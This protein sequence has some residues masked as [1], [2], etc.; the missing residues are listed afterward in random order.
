M[1]KILFFCLFIFMISDAF[2]SHI[3]G[4][5]MSY[6]Y[7]GPGTNPGT[8]KYQVTLKMYKDCA[9]ATALDATVLFSVYNTA[10]AT[11]FINLTG[12]A[13]SAIQTIQKSPVDP[14]IDDNIETLVCF[15]YRTYTTIIDNLPITPDGYTIAF[16]RCCR[17]AGMENIFSTDVGSTF[18]TVIPG[19][20]IAGAETNTS[21]VFKGFLILISV[22]MRRME[23]HWFILFIM[24]FPEEV[25]AL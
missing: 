24:H 6:I 14:C 4:G 17:V 12:I 3:S 22:Q 23:I 19:D 7:L 8:L 21:P 2:A 25:Q 5:E 1:K 20:L 18:F 16:Q 15:Q 13:G 11:L 10:S 9:S